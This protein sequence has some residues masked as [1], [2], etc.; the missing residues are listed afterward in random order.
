MFSMGPFYLLKYLSPK[1]YWIPEIIPDSI[2]KGFVRVFKSF[3]SSPKAEQR[4]IFL[5][6]IYKICI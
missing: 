5:V 3:Y 2:H 6:T 4:P 1:S